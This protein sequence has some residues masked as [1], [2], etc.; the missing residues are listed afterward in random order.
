[1][2]EQRAAAKLAPADLRKFKANTKAW[3]FFSAAA[4]WYRRKMMYRIVSARR[5][6]TRASRLARVIALSAAG[7]TLD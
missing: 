4:P 6:E 3:K 2:Y 7:K 1:V 5:P